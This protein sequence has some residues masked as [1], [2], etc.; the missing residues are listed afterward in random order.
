LVGQ[1][2]IAS[3]LWTEK[4]PQKAHK[5]EHKLWRDGRHSRRNN[6]SIQNYRDEMFQ[7]VWYILFCNV[8][9]IIMGPCSFAADVTVRLWRVTM[10]PGKAGERVVAEYSR[11][12]TNVCG[13]WFR[14]TSTLQFIMFPRIGPS[15][16]DHLSSQT[17]F[18]DVTA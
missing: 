9:P 15:G 17:R 1:I 7:T 4:S 3:E 6:F 13:Y 10:T 2:Y 5:P 11:E 18:F 8:I 12:S 14:S 16:Q